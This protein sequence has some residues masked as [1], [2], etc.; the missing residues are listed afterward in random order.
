MTGSWSD[1]DW[2]NT[3]DCYKYITYTIYKYTLYYYKGT[4]AVYVI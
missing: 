2:Q 3:H 1:L 4:C